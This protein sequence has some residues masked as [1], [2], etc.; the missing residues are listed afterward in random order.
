MLDGKA[1]VTML[2]RERPS[3]SFFQALRP[4]IRHRKLGA[5]GTQFSVLGSDAG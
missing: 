2:Q 3:T 4:R 5:N 1:T